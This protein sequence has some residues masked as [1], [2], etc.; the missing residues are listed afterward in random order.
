MRSS[1]P[2]P[3]KPV[4]RR[5]TGA[6]RPGVPEGP[7]RPWEMNTYPGNRHC[8]RCR[9]DGCPQKSRHP[10]APPVV[11]QAPF[12]SP[13]WPTLPL[14]PG[15]PLVPLVPRGTGGRTG[16]YAHPHQFV[17]RAT[18]QVQPVGR[19]TPLPM[20]LAVLIVISWSSKLLRLVPLYGHQPRR[21]GLYV[22]KVTVNDGLRT[23]RFFPLGIETT[24][25][26]HVGNQVHQVGN[27]VRSGAQ[28]NN[29]V[30][31]IG[32]E[33]PYVRLAGFC[34]VPAVPE[35]APEGVT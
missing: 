4:V 24:V 23:V 25:Y 20:A 7:C 5:R 15:N 21:I 34:L 18:V 19:T 9:Q 6:L 33:R 10:A 16:L 29:V 11:Q 14:A 17:R 13:L 31:G 22:K 1:T 8:R 27:V 28:V 32:N 3:P 30:R 2:T 26:F 12:S 35:P